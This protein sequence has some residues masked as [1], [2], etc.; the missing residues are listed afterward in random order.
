MLTLLEHLALLA[1]R[2]DLRG[3]SEGFRGRSMWDN[4]TQTVIIVGVLMIVVV[5]LLLISRL[6]ENYELRVTTNSANGVFR[7]LCRIHKLDH[8]S[9]RLLKRLASYW[10][11]ESPA[12]LFVCPDLFLAERLPPEWKEDTERVEQLGRKLFDTN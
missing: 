8:A 12:Y 4:A 9:R 1:R 10:N 6:H 2:E 7:E 5:V 3:I 11:L